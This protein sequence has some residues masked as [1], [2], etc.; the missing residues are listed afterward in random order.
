MLDGIVR[1]RS[2]NLVIILDRLYSMLD[3]Y[4]AAGI[5]SGCSYKNESDKENCIKEGKIILDKLAHDGGGDDIETEDKKQESGP[6]KKKKGTGKRGGATKSKKV[7][8]P[9]K[10]VMNVLP[11][12][13]I[14]ATLKREGYV[15]GKAS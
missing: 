6:P 5:L 12:P 3:A 7:V 13:E 10:I 4:W 2:L 8:S 14:V 9:Q 11:T 1:R 15:V